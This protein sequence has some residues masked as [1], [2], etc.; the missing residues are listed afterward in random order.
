MSGSRSS[1]SSSVSW[2]DTVPCPSY[3]MPN[4]SYSRLPKEKPDCQDSF[5]NFYRVF[6][7]KVLLK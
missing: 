1:S 5:G 3:V 4:L 6:C 2:D 7:N